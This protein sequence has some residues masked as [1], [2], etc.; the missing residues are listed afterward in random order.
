MFFL[1]KGGRK[2]AHQQKEVKDDL[3]WLSFLFAQVTHQPGRMQ[4][5][6]Q[7]DHFFGAFCLDVRT[8][9]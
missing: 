4:V 7:R 2:G 5:R 3:S 1:D 8:Q 6:T 9:D